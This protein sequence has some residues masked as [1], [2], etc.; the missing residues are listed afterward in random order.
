MRSAVPLSLLAS[1][2][3]GQAHAQL[4][5][6]AADH[7]PAIGQAFAYEQAAYV[8]PP[9][10]GAALLYDYS[11]LTS[12]GTSSLNWIDPALYS[13]SAANPTAEL[14]LAAGPDTM[15]YATTAEGLE[16]VGERNELLLL[17]STVVL[18]IQ[19]TNNLLELK[20]PLAFGDAWSDVVAGNVASDGSTGSRNGVI[21]AVADAYGSVVLPG[22]TTAPV[23]RVRK[24][25]V[26][27]VQIPIGGN[28]VNVAHKRI[29]VDHYAPWLKMPI[30]SSYVDSLTYI[31]SVVETGT[32][33]MLADPV[34][35]AGARMDMGVVV[36]PNPAVDVLSVAFMERMPAGTRITLCDAAG[37]VLRDRR[38]ATAA[39]RHEEPVEGIAD[40]VYLLQVATPQGALSTHRFV[41]R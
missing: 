30:L 15:L 36:Y 11:T 3:A 27:T 23:L 6:T 19:H 28:P 5:L 25:L 9:P 7:L 4:T 31:V 35:L 20:L 37:R 22:G 21:T 32:R 2:C 33:Y 16:L 1:L 24:E 12:T 40:G 14:A 17:G 10:G 18:D 38:L 26:E 41:K 39:V 8:A 34:G 29:Q 13:N